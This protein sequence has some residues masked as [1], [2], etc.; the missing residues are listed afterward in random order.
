MKE[1]LIFLDIAKL[2]VPEL[3]DQAG[4]V[5][6]NDKDARQSLNINCWPVSI[7]FGLFNDS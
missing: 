5:Y 7:H 4:M 2:Y 3:D 6:I 1:T